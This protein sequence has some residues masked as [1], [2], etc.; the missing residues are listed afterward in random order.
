MIQQYKKPAAIKVR[1][2]RI[3]QAVLPA[4]RYF[5]CQPCEP[6]YARFVPEEVLIADKEFTSRIHELD[7][8]KP[9]WFSKPSWL[10]LKKIGQ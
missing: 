7:M 1:H 3:C 2:C 4:T 8:P 5:R 9:T 6:D 10:K